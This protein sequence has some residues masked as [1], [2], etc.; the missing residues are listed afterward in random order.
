VSIF[1]FLP[2]S[3]SLFFSVGNFKNISTNRAQDWE[4]GEYVA[5]VLESNTLYLSTGNYFLSVI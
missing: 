3:H 5:S 1:D 2:F 4:E